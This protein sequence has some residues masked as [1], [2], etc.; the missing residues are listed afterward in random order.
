MITHKYPRVGAS[1]NTGG[2]WSG[3]WR[4]HGIVQHNHLRVA[5][6]LLKWPQKQISSLG[7]D[8]T[9]LHTPHH[10]PAHLHMCVCTCEYKDTNP[11]P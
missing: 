10:A 9:L 4:R 5:G 8:V 1:G 11:K 3:L 2:E 6:R 7:K